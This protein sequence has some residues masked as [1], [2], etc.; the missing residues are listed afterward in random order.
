MYDLKDYLLSAFF[1]LAL[2][3]LLNICAYL[4]TYF[5]RRIGARTAKKKI[6]L[7]LIISLLFV[8]ACLPSGVFFLKTDV[9]GSRWFQALFG[10]AIG[11]L[12]VGLFV[13]FLEKKKIK[14]ILAVYGLS[15]LYMLF[16]LFPLGYI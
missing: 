15:L 1:G 10:F 13:L 3:T 14:R 16:W 12:P 7:A 4:V 2:G 5:A 6:A 8:V 9:L 11:V